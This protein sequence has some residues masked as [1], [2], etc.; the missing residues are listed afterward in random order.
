M[1][2]YWFFEYFITVFEM[3]L[4]FQFMALVFDKKAKTYAVMLGSMVIAA[5]ICVI[6]LYS[7]FTQYTLFAG[8]FMSAYTGGRLFHI[9]IRLSLGCSVFY[10]I[11]FVAFIDVSCILLTSFLTGNEAVWKVL[12]ESLSPLRLLFIIACKIVLYLGFCL[13]RNLVRLH[14]AKRIFKEY[15]WGVI[16]IGVISFIGLTYL[17]TFL[18]SRINSSLTG[19]WIFF[20]SLVVIIFIALISYYNY[21]IVIETKDRIEMRNNILEANYNALKLVTDAEEK[22]AHDFR[23]HLN[24]LHKYLTEKN[25]Q[26]ALAYVA[27]LS[28]PF[29]SLNHDVWTGNEVMDFILNLKRAEAEDKGI[30]F[31]IDTKL[32]D[33]HMK[34]QDLNSILSNVLDNAIEASQGMTENKRIDVYIHT[35]NEMLILKVKNNHQNSIMKRGKRIITSKEDK[36]KHGLGI[37]IVKKTIE[38]YGGYMDIKYDESTFQ[39]LLTIPMGDGE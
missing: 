37:S 8:V 6:N 2:I 3:Y 33:F 34:D 1:S 7:L 26:A 12:S 36:R 35:Q 31:Q 13:F 38:R 5:V 28:Q 27:S 4:G 11:N 9:K 25:D 18:I 10:S 29:D 15:W 20:I 22:S 23:N 16:I 19:R 21:R 30:L 32:Y 17:N 24:M 14:P 39:I